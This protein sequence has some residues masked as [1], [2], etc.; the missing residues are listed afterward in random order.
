[1]SKDEEAFLEAVLRG[2]TL[3]VYWYLL[4]RGGDH[5]IGVRE[6]QRALGFS[7]PSVALHHLEKLRDLKLLDKTGG[8]YLVAREVKVGFLRLFLK[9]G[10][11]VLPRYLFY[12]V[13]LTTMLAAYVALY[14][15]SLSA[16]NLVALIFGAA[17]SLILWYE[18]YRVLKEAPW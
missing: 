3:R 2:K 9:L 7:S 6:V 1:M 4:K 17:A 12:A 5:P 15:Q 14:P 10:R 18:T 8:E 11:L 16:H 13:F